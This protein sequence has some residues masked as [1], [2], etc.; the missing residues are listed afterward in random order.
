MGQGIGGIEDHEIDRDRFFQDFFHGL[1]N[2]LQV[3]G[4]INFLHVFSKFRDKPDRDLFV[5]HLDRFGIHQ[6]ASGQ[7]RQLPD[8]VDKVVPADGKLFHSVTDLDTQGKDMHRLLI[9][10]MEYYRNLLVYIVAGPESTL[11]DLT[12][13]QIDKL[14]EQ[15]KTAS[16]ERILDIV[17]LL[18]DTESQLRFALSKRTLFETALIRCA[19]AAMMVSIDEIIQQINDLKA[20]ITVGAPTT[21]GAKTVTAQ[22]S[23]PTPAPLTVKSKPEEPRAEPVIQEAT[24][25]EPARPEPVKLEPARSEPE[26]PAYS[27]LGGGVEQ[28]TVGWNDFID[29]VGQLAPLARSYLVDAK[30]VEVKDEQVTIGFIPEFAENM[31]KINFPRNLKAIHKAMEKVLEKPVTVDFM[32]LDSADPLPHEI[33]VVKNEPVDLEEPT[34]QDRPAEE[35]TKPTRTKQ[36]WLKDPAVQK[37]LEMF[38]GDIADIRD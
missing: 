31:E 7:R 24:R 12:K 28:L 37:T 21:A 13:A 16:P 15:G 6:I 9:E 23:K 30:P 33:P 35:E 8:V 18:T 38:N 26:K 11:K 34:A 4:E 3:S 25:P 1:M 32:V 17:E 19:R 2:R 14:E 36:E 20:G 5:L 29:H 27:G 22:A 10:L